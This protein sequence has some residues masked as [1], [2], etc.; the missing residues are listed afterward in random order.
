VAT[1]VPS[2]RKLD[3]LRREWQ[4]RLKLRDWTISVKFADLKF[5]RDLTDIENPVGACEHFA[6]T[7]QARIW[8]LQPSEW[9]AEP[10]ER[11]QDVE[12]TIVHELLHCHFAAFGDRSDVGRLYVEQTIETL[13]AA[14]IGLKRQKGG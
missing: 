7:K 3:D 9:D 1:A 8:V 2:Q 13:T 11:Q 12:D 10:N 14:L 6:E 4:K 5:L